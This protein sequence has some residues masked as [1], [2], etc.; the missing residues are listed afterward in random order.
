MTRARK[1]Q[2]REKMLH[3]IFAIKKN[4]YPTHM[5]LQNQDN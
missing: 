4:I 5:T 1:Q 2:T 3:N